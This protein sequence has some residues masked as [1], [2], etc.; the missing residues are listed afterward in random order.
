MRCMGTQRATVSVQPQPNTAPRKVR[1]S[2]KVR[3]AIDAMVE[4]GL[5]RETAAKHAGIT[6]HALYCAL[7]LPHVL[8]Y[9]SERLRVLRESEA[10][11]SIARVATLADDAQSEHVK[12]GANELLM[13]IEGISKVQRSE[14]L[15]VHQHLIPGLTVNRGNWVPHGDV[16]EAEVVQSDSVKRIGSPVPFP[17][18]NA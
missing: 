10:A 5:K 3:A 6:D 18:D 9:R 12:L 13:G 17:T 14:N 1:L 11:R 2:P 16:L 15:H 8:A 7:R 4:G